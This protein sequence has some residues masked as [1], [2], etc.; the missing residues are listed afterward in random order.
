MLEFLENFNADQ[1]I[2]AGYYAIKF[3]KEWARSSAAAG[4]YSSFAGL[5]PAQM[6]L[7]KRIVAEIEDCEGQSVL[8]M[9]LVKIDQ[10]INV[11]G[12]KIQELS[13]R[14]L[15]ADRARGQILLEELRQL[16]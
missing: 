11:I 15:H 12:S 7:A 3:I 4:E 9:P 16:R 10:Y 5:P 2:P 6:Q 8:A 1:V 13:R 14:D